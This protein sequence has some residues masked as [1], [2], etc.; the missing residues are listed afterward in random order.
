MAW[1]VRCSFSTS[2]KRTPSSPYSPNPMPGDTATLASVRRRFA[3]SSE[4]SGRNASGIG[5]YTNIVARG[6]S[7]GQPIRL[8]PLTNT[9]RRFR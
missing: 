9:S 2:A 5:A 1:R 8:S 6:L 7:T 3:N 4:P